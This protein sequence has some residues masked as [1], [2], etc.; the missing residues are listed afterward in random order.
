MNRPLVERVQIQNYGCI[1]DV[2]LELTPLH[3]LIGP[4]DSGKSTVLSALRMLTTLAA[5]PFGN[6]SDSGRLGQALGQNRT[7]AF[8]ATTAGHTWNINKT[9]DGKLHEILVPGPSGPLSHNDGS[10]L[11]RS[12]PDLRRRLAGST[13]LRLEPDELR[14]PTQ[15]IPDGTPLRFTN[16]FGSGLPALYDAIVTRNMPAFVEISTR[17]RELF[18]TVKS[19]HLKNPSSGTKA[20]GVQLNDGSEVP[21]E[22]MSEGMLYYLAY[23]ILPHLESTA[24]LLIEEPENGLHPA[25]IR[26]VMTVLKEISQKVQVVLATHSPLVV[27]ELDGDQVTVLTRSIEEGTKATRLSDTPDFSERSRVYAL[28]ELWVS[29][30]DGNVEAPLFRSPDPVADPGELA[31]GEGIG[32]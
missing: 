12:V 28:G 25:R 10:L 23:A 16:E 20:L 29:Y 32:G 21:A 15:L 1:R 18:P 3:A 31:G 19:L 26:E 2:T 9:A 17:L 7:F 11:L 27:N 6:V 14:K 22:F 24:M 5:G 30:A 8:N 4:N 13:L